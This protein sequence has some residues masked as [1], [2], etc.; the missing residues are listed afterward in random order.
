MKKFPVPGTLSFDTVMYFLKHALH[1]SLLTFEIH[2]C[3]GECHVRGV[4]QPE[5]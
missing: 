4:W 5:G 3:T 2:H 1:T